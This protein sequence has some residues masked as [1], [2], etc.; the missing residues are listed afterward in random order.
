MKIPFLKI[1]SWEKE[2][3]RKQQQKDQFLMPTTYPTVNF[4]YDMLN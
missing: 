3:V 2:G 4:E 1:K